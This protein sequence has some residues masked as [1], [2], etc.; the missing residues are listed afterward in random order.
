MRSSRPN[1]TRKFAKKRLF[2]IA[3]LLLALPMMYFDQFHQSSAAESIATTTTKTADLFRIN[4][5]VVVDLVANQTDVKLAASSGNVSYYIVSSTV[6]QGALGLV[7]YTPDA[8]PEWSY[9]Y[10][11]RVGMLV[12]VDP[13]GT[14]LALNAYRL[15][16]ETYG[17]RIT[18]AWLHTLIG[19]NVFEPLTIGQDVEGVT[20]ATVTSRAIVDGIR[21]AGRKVVDDYGANAPRMKQKTNGILSSISYAWAII[22]PRGLAETTVMIGLFASAIVAYEWADRRMRYVV[23][24]AAIVFVGFYMGRMVSIVDL[25]GLPRAGLPPLLPNTYWYALF[26]LALAT[27]II[28]GRL[29]CG[30][31]CPFGAFTQILHNLSPIKIKIPMRIQKRLIIAKY[32][33]LVVIASGV[34]LGDLWITGFEPFQTFF[35]LTGQWWMWLIAA[36]AVLASIP[37]ER[38]F[39]R[40]FCPAGAVLSLAASLRLMEIRRWPECKQCLVCQRTCPTGA[41]VGSKISSLEC[42]NCRECEMNYL[43]PKMCPHYSIQRSNSKINVVRQ[44]S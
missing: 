39:C 3:L 13:N 15:A 26:G 21:E 4:K 18:P 22:G 5:T 38:F 25:T 16:F 14:I 17:D 1:N 23:M 30:Y 44:P 31:L 41:I 35:F 27:S 2:V 19:R 43:S 11:S 34:A 9:G 33:V 29:Y 10:V 36:A 28:W 12:Y 24:G 42:M 20:S 40:Y 32:L 6:D 8:A 7:Y 37:A